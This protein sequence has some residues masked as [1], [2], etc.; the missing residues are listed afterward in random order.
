MLKYYLKLSWLSVKRTPVLTGLMILAIGLGISVSITVLT[1]D[2]MMSQ[3][4]IPGKS[5]QLFHVQLDSFHETGRSGSPDGLP[6]QLTYQDAENLSYSKIPTRQTRGLETGF[7][8]IPAKQGQTPF[9][10]SA[11]AIDRDFFDMFNVPFQFGAPWDDVIDDRP[12]EVVIIGKKLNDQLFDGANSVGKTINLNQQE[13]T[14]IGVLEDWELTPRFYDV[15]NGGFSNTEQLYVPFSLLPILELP[16]WGNT[17][18]WKPEL[19]KTYQDRLRSEKLWIQYWVQLD[20]EQQQQEYREFLSAYIQQQKSLQRFAKKDAR[21]DIKNVVQWMAYNQIVSDDNSVLVGLSFMF[22]AVCMIN[23]I[24]L[25]LAKFLR[26]AP[27]VGVRRALGASRGEIFTQHLIDVALIGLSGGVLGL[28]LAQ[29]GL[30]GIA[31]LYRNYERL[32]HMDLTLVFLAIVI[33][34]GSSV[35]AGLYPAWKICRTNPSIYLKTQ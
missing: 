7:T 3:D 15:N 10:E 13:F 9:M 31:S 24:G 16:T 20:S 34:L 25:L 8:I 29:L 4:P 22:L 23:T 33:A 30:V 19:L 35:L 14:V 18:G 32:V 28:L 6:V 5:H 21:A 26:R 27:E 2:Y 1:V 12:R 11:R 17:N